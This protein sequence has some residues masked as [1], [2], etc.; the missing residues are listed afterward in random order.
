MSVYLWRKNMSMKLIRFSFFVLLIIGLWSGAATGQGYRLNLLIPDLP[1]KDVILSHRLGLKFYTDDTVKTDVN[2]KATLEGTDPMPEGMYQL[3]FPDK[4]FLEFFLDK[5]QIFSIVTRSSALS[6]STSFSGSPENSRFM[7]WQQKYGHNRSRTSLI[8]GRLKK[9]SLDPDSTKLLNKELQEIQRSN[10]HLWDSAI[11]DLAGTL[12]GNFIKGMKP[13]RIPES[14]GKQD[15][16]ESQMKQYWF[17]RTHFFDNVDFADE[18]LLRTPLMETKLDQYFKQV[19]PLIPDTLIR[20]AKRVIG[21]TKPS[22][23]MYRF[24]VQYLFN[25]YTDPEVMGTDAVYVYLAENYYL[26]GEAPW[27]DSANLQGIRIRVKELK[28]LLLGTFPPALE[29]LAKTDDQPVEIKDIKSKYLILYF[30]SPDCGFCKEATPKL[31]KQYVDL[32]QLGAEV[33]AINTHTDKE[34]WLKFIADHQLNWINLYFLQKGR[35]M[36]ERYQALT[37]PAIYILDGERRIMAK[38]ISVD[39]VGPFLKHHVTGK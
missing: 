38:S 30:W 1:N 39:Q 23:I 17:V 19:V 35:E 7:E 32:K 18:R 16:P 20:E 14:L 31:Y 6:D 15:N 13:V 9:G 11:Q 8:Q 26:N 28:P 33:V 12:P 29:G 21:L 27:I 3:V 34:S 22:G 4:K 2:G 37:T 5:N 25:L 24:V 36:I 10:N